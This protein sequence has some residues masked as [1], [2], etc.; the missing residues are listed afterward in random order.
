M[1]MRASCAGVNGPLDRLPQ[2][3]LN[4]RTYDPV[5]VPPQENDTPNHFLIFVDHPTRLVRRDAARRGDEKVQL[6]VQCSRDHT[7]SKWQAMPNLHIRSNLWQSA[8]Q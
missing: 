4:A 2:L 6:L 8:G 5:L 7:R 1:L 3:N